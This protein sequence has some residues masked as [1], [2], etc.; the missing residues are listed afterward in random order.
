MR[1]IILFL[2]LQLPIWTACEPQAEDAPGFGDPPVPRRVRI[3]GLLTRPDPAQMEDAPDLGYRP[4][5]HG[6]QIPDD[7][8]MGAPSSVAWM[9]R[10]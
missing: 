6:L 4:A 5:P 2:A 10:P 9:D 1:W 8:E 3:P 7:V